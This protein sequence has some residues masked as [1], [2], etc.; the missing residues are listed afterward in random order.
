MYLFITVKSKWL[1]NRQGQRFKSQK[2][3][4][5]LLNWWKHDLNNSAVIIWS[6]DQ[7]VSGFLSKIR[8]PQNSFSSSF[9]IYGS[10][11]KNECD[12]IFLTNLKITTLLTKS[13]FSKVNNFSR[14]INH[15]GTPKSVTTNI[16]AFVMCDSFVLEWE[17]AWHIWTWATHSFTA[18]LVII[19]SYDKIIIIKCKL[20]NSRLGYYWKNRLFPKRSR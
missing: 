15:S 3:C 11:T 17:N 7:T 6:A 14:F 19:V 5:K 10:S 18:H 8:C 20:A 2:V 16:Y 13:K 12:E 4:I 1:M 9:K